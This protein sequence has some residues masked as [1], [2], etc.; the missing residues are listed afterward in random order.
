MLKWQRCLC[1]ALSASKKAFFK[2][3]CRSSSSSRASLH[4]AVNSCSHETFSQLFQ[5][6]IGLKAED[7]PDELL[8]K[9]VAVVGSVRAA[10]AIE[11]GKVQH[12]VVNLGDAETILVLFSKT[13]SR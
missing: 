11:Y 7:Q 6:F 8:H 10:V 1:R 3:L 2:T 4:K 13:H 9:G 5:Q 12:A